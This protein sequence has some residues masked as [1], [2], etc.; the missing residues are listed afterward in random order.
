MLGKKGA[1]KPVKLREV[2]LADQIRCQPLDGKVSGK[3]GRR[4]V[5]WTERGSN[6]R[7]TVE[8]GGGVAGHFALGN[9]IQTEIVETVLD[10]F[11]DASTVVRGYV[12][13]L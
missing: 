9:L 2:V 8:V 13:I 3:R 11:A 1:R 5:G 6:L 12:A 10:C 4:E 7:G